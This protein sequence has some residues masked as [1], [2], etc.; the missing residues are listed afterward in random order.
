LERVN[1]TFK[2]KRLYL[3][4]ALVAHMRIHWLRLPY[5]PEYCPNGFEFFCLSAVTYVR[6][7]RLLIIIFVSRRV[8]PIAMIR[9]DDMRKFD[10]SM[11]TS[12][13]KHAA[14][15]VVS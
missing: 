2:V 1:Y 12:G 7:R 13:T 11:S 5:F 14:V 10:T 6:P 9:L 15:R 8:D 3:H 4:A